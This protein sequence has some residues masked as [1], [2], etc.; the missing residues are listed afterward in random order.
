MTLPTFSTLNLLQIK[1]I[2]LAFTFGQIKFCFY[3]LEC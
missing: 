1:S 2:D 3:K